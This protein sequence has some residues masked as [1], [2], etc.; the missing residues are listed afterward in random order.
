MAEKIK[1][2]ATIPQDDI[3]DQ[4]LVEMLES[5]AGNDPERIM[6]LLNNPK[7]TKE[8]TLELIGQ[9]QSYMNWD[10]GA[11]TYE[12]IAWRDQVN[13][14][15][16]NGTASKET[17]KTR[18]Y[19]MI[20]GDD[21]FLIS[22]VYLNDGEGLR[23]FT[24]IREEEYVESITPQGRFQDFPT[25]SAL[26]NGLLISGVIIWIAVGVTL[27]HSVIR[28]QKKLK[29]LWPFVVFL[30]NVFIQVQRSGMNRSFFIRALTLGYPR[31]FTYQNGASL[32]VLMIP[33]GLI[34]YWIFYLKWRKKTE[35][36]TDIP[37]PMSS[38]EQTE[39]P[40]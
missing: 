32:F 39:S 9:I 14:V 10:G 1:N 3:A 7:A 2:Q 28:G 24:V 22:F 20:T 18:Q 8:D 37:S 12:A 11:Y 25:N 30:G 19:R 6:E 34:V 26:Q 15:A 35:G 21:S 27:L 31:Y 17:Q 33:V 16:G 38:E 29:W 40:E 13:A 36:M 23:S 4:Y 5:I